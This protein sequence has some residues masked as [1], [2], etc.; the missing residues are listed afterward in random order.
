M[1][2]V[3]AVFI[4]DLEVVLMEPV[5]EV[6]LGRTCVCLSNNMVSI[7]DNEGIMGVGGGWSV[8]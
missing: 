6:R 5:D 4:I 7:G 1:L 3:E 2:H 8:R